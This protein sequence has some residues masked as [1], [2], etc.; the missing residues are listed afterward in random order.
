MTPAREL[1]EYVWGLT[2]DQRVVFKSQDF[3]VSLVR[4][5]V[6][7]NH[8]QIRMFVA[9][10]SNMNCA[11]QYLIDQTGAEEEF[12]FD[13]PFFVKDFPRRLGCLT[14]EEFSEVRRVRAEKLVQFLKKVKGE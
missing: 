2:T 3:A 13:P 9:H 5:E 12:G 10:P 11:E 7:P 8:R 6:H 4:T 1:F 14:A